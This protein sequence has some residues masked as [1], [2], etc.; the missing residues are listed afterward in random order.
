[1]SR[2]ASLPPGYRW[3]EVGSCA[4]STY[5]LILEDWSLTWVEGFVTNYEPAPSAI[6]CWAVAEDG[7]VIDRAPPVRNQRLVYLGVE[8]PTSIVIQ[9]VESRGTVGCVLADP[10]QGYPLLTGSWL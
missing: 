7:Q 2:T 5:D 6:H 4:F 3:R 8:I 1:M 10:E 9:Q